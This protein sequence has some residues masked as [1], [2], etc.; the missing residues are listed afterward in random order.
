MGDDC[1][2]S[3]VLAQ[4]L[5]EMAATEPDASVRSQLASTAK[6]LPAADGL[7]IARG[8]LL[9][10]E[11]LHDAHIPLLLWWAVEDKCDSGRAQILG[12]MENSGL[13]DHPIARETII[14]RLAR[15]FGARDAGAFVAAGCGAALASLI[16]VPNPVLAML[17]A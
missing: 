17:C 3:R 1:R 14:P 4:R 5:I 11:D 10:N 9:R 16:W 8:L 15:R 2:V 13:W 6:R 7:P 12:W